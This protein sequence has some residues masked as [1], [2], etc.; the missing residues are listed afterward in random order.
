VLKI[1]CPS[2]AVRRS[3]FLLTSLPLK[4]S[5]CSRPRRYFHLPPHYCTSLTLRQTSTGIHSLLRHKSSGIIFILLHEILPISFTIVFPRLNL[6]ACSLHAGA[7]Y[8]LFHDPRCKGNKQVCRSFLLSDRNVPWCRR[9]LP[10]GEL[11]WVD[12]SRSIRG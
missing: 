3:F 11:Q 10:P 8:D 2:S 1:R 12:A 7:S 4:S 9:M 5:A 6:L